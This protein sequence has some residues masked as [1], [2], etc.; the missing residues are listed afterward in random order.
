MYKARDVRDNKV[1]AL[2]RLI[3]RKPNSGF[4]LMAVRE[5]KFL[6]SLRHKNLVN[7]K[8]IASSKGA[9]HL[10]KIAFMFIVII[11]IATTIMIITQEMK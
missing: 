4:P 10:G 9:E 3:S 11:I 1:V 5:I 2:K 6:K 8:D 7:L